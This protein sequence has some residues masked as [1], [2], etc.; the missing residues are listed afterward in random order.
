M[1]PIPASSRVGGVLLSALGFADLP[2]GKLVG[3]YRG[4]SVPC[5][6]TRN[7]SWSDVA[8]AYLASSEANVRVGGGGAYRSISSSKQANF[9]GNVRRFGERYA[10]EEDRET[11]S[12]G[13]EDISVSRHPPSYYRSSCCSCCCLSYSS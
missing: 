9:L 12:E 4:S 2:S 1:P 3:S 13:H 11:A 10:L 6:K 5:T 7:D 8:S